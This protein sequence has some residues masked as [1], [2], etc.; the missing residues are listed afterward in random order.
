MTWPIGRADERVGSFMPWLRAAVVAT[1]G[2]ILELGAGHFSTPYLAEFASQTD[3]EFWTY[4]YDSEWAEAARKV[5]PNIAEKPSEIPDR[6]WSVVLVDCEGWARRAFV[7]KLRPRTDIFVIHD[8]QD[9]W[10]PEDVL[11]TFQYRF[12]S[13]EE[14]RTSVVSDFNE[15]SKILP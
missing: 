3:R 7:Y 11:A 15:I 5:S 8:T 14:P 12:D 9:A 1:E 6:Q 4:E 2:P 13:D 10:V